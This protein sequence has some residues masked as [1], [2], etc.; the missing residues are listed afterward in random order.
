MTTP[1]TATTR[2]GFTLTEVL[3]AAGL[4]ML[5]MAVITQAFS[6]GMETLSRLKSVGE[7]QQRLRSF[8]T[9][10]RSDLESEHFDGRSGS[11]VSDMKLNLLANLP[12]GVDPPWR[13][14]A[15][16][17]FAIKQEGLSIPE[18][19]ETSMQEGNISTRA[20]N[21][22][23]Q[24][25]VRRDASRGDRVFTA[26][27]PQTVVAGMTPN[28]L[29]QMTNQ[30]RSFVSTWA[31]V[32]YFLDTTAPV[33]ATPGS[34]G[35]VPLY[36]LYRRV[37]IL[38][39]FGNPTTMSWMSIAA[40]QGDWAERTSLQSLSYAPRVVNGVDHPIN[41]P[42]SVQNPNNRLGGINMVRSGGQVFDVIARDRDA[43]PNNNPT[44]TDLLLTDVISF[45]I[46]ANWDGGSFA[47]GSPMD[48]LHLTYEFPYSDLP[49]AVNPAN[50][51]P[52]NPAIG[53]ARVF[54]TWYQSTDP[55]TGLPTVNWLTPGNP[56]CLPQPMR[57]RSIQ[58]KVRVWDRHNGQT[59]QVTIMQDL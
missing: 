24:M 27:L 11:K 50:G 52:R 28:A 51:T 53:D 39:E 20:N 9:I 56:E 44:G 1:S 30:P 41:D 7:L 23:L 17:F 33:G 59:R 46:K 36:G 14:P 6:Q 22:I 57:L 18:G 32:T 19:R 4:A 10:V 55:A 48:N 58:I 29:A 15:R 21:H 42:S 31:E 47:P 49:R 40:S 26:E 37:R 38:P 5:I 16:G 25:T 13:P 12:A 35:T 8:E 54:D 34:G 3:V 43:S 2:R 45:E